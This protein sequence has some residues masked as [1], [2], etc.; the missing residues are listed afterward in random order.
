[1]P[2]GCE[3]HVTAWKAWKVDKGY[4]KGIYGPKWKPNVP[5]IARRAQPASVV[6]YKPGIYGLKEWDST[7]LPLYGYNVYGQ[8]ALWGPIM[9]HSNG[10]RARYAYPLWVECWDEK[11]L[12]LGERYNIPCRMSQLDEPKVDFPTFP[13]FGYWNYSSDD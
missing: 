8:V 5:C 7:I 2:N 4:L 3:G 6:G 10:F 9:E 1:M 12:D 13:F 11:Y